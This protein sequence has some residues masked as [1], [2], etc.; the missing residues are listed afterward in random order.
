[1]NGAPRAKGEAPRHPSAKACHGAKPEAERT[2]CNRRPHSFAQQ[3]ATAPWSVERSSSKSCSIRRP[4]AI[5][6]LR[7]CPKP[8]SQKLHNKPRRYQHDEHRHAGGR[9]WRGSR[10]NWQGG[11]AH[12]TPPPPA[13]QGARRGAGSTTTPFGSP[14][15]KADAREAQ[16]IPNA[17]NGEHKE[18]LSGTIGKERRRFWPRFSMLTGDRASD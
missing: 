8:W 12:A 13:S 14:P 10:P 3:W 7:L 18:R 9:L 15:S 17:R 2:R 6:R 5:G 11:R 16:P 4:D 1:M